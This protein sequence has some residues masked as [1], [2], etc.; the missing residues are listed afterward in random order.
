MTLDHLILKLDPKSNI[1]LARILERLVFDGMISRDYRV[2]SPGN[3]GE[4]QK[5]ATPEEIPNEV[6]DWHTGTILPVTARN[7][8][9]VYSLP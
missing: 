8:R 1:N 9:V 7:L 4:I 3:H 6:F 2:E 5:F